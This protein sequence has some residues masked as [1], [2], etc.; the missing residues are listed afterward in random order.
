[1]RKI[2]FLSVIIVI[3]IFSCKKESFF[4]DGSAQLNFSIDTLQFDTVFTTVG[5]ATQ[6]FK[7]YNPYSKPIKISSISL[8][9]GNS[10]FF[11]MNV[12]GVSARRIENIEIDAKD[13]LYIFVEVNV[14]PNNQSNPLVVV[15]SIIFQTNGN[16]QDIKLVACGQD[17]NLINGNDTSGI[18][19]QSTIW[20]SVKPYLVINSMLVDSEVTLTITQGTKIYFHK[21]SR[22]YVKGTLIANGTLDEPIIFRNDRLEHWYDDV[23]GQWPGIFFVSA[24]VSGSKD[25]V[26]NYCEIKNAIIGIQADAQYGTNPKITISNSKVLNMNAVGIFAQ[27]TSIKAWNCVIANCGQYAAA[28]TLGGFYEFYH[29]TFINNWGYSNRQTPSLVL[30]NYYQDI[31]GDIH[32]YP[33]DK[34]YFGNCIIYGN[35]ENEIGLDPFPTAGTFNYTF[36]NSLL[37]IDPATNTSDLL[38]WDNIFKNENPSLK[39]PE[40]NDYSLDTLSFAKDK[41]DLGIG[42]LYPLDFKMNSRLNYGLPDLGAFERIE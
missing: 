21:D 16:T 29:C 36:K 24:V 14:D 15:D 30:N 11:R 3:V 32:V 13:S 31:Y 39:N 17:V 4:T 25:N 20:N 9:K 12:N 7:V 41:G 23:P 34:A 6:N 19:S 28:L 35:K 22:M 33:L 27:N 10:S 8:A 2:F 40:Y 18:I 26:L 37:K 42:N 5:S 38:H 1:M